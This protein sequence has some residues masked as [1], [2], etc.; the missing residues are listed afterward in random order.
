MEEQRSE[1]AR[2]GGG[3]REDGEEGEEEWGEEAELYNHG[4][5]GDRFAE[6]L[7]YMVKGSSAFGGEGL[8]GLE[9]DRKSGQDVRTQNVMAC[10]AIANVVK[11]SLG[12]VGLDKMLVDD[13]GD[14][15][16]T[17][18]GATILNLL[19]V[20]HPAG[21]VLVDLAQL[22]DKEVGDG[23]TSVVILAAELLRVDKLGRDALINVAK[24][25]M[26]SKI[27][28]INPDFFAAMA[29]DS[30]MSVK[31]VNSSGDVRYP[32]KAINVLKA[33]GKSSQ[34]SR[35]IAGYALNCTRASQAMPTVVNKAKIALLDYDLRK[36]KMSLGVQVEY[37]PFFALLAE[38]SL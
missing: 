17:N 14:T 33:H 8:T 10:M 12:P 19:E 37:T 36:Y 32:V 6:R 20:D 9:G 29:V 34:E 27:L 25:S 24:T 26:S 13:I 1:V 22:Q 15:T 35:R 3:G 38:Q 4:T 5:D 21:K 18:D 16:V 30:V 23:T 7:G 2:E 28:N 11:S 31:T